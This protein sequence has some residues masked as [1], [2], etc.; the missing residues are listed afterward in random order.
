MYCALGGQLDLFFFHGP[1]WLRKITTGPHSLPHDSIDC[2]V[3]RY[4]KLKIHG[5]ELILDKF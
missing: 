4:A 5:S 3:V 2:P 1:L